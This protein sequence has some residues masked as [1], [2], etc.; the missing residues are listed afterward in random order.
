MKTIREKKQKEKQK[1]T[2]SIAK[3]NLAMSHSFMTSAKKK[4][5]L[6]LPPLPRS[7]F[8]DKYPHFCLSSPHS[9]TPLTAIQSIPQGNFRIFLE[10]F[11]NE[12]SIVSY[13][14]FFANAHNI[15]Y[16]PKSTK[17]D[18]KAN[19]LSPRR[20]LLKANIPFR[21][22]NQPQQKCQERN[23]VTKPKQLLQN[24]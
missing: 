23:G 5:G 24:L 9:W 15:Y 7:P 17:T 22:T 21:T 20:L 1:K 11:N 14:F 13:S 6:S 16:S 19:R 10:D 4:L 18:R 8:I 3:K 2:Y 12:I